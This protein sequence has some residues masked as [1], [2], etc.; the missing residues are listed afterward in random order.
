MGFSLVRAIEDYGIDANNLDRR[1][2]IILSDLSRVVRT[3]IIP[4]LSLYL[5]E[6]YLI[7]TKKIGT[8][9]K[10]QVEQSNGH[11]TPTMFGVHLRLLY[12]G[13]PIY[14]NHPKSEEVAKIQANLERTL[15]RLAMYHN[16]SKIDIMTE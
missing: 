4:E 9:T 14:P 15:S 13:E 8:Y 16:I 10:G 12:E 6:G 7:D 1:R 3:E 11:Q 5:Q 2:R